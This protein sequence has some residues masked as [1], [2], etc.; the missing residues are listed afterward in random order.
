M[1]IKTL[2]RKSNSRNLKAQA[3]DSHVAADPP[4]Q[5]TYP[6]A[7]NGPNVLDDLQRSHVRR[8][9]V[10]SAAPSPFVPRSR[11]E[12]PQTA[13]YSGFP[14]GGRRNSLPTSDNASERTRSG[15][16]MSSTF[17]SNRRSS[18]AN[19]KAKRASWFPKN[20]TPL[21]APAQIQT[22]SP[23]AEIETHQ[24][25]QRA[26]S[27]A[28]KHLPGK[29]PTHTMHASPRSASYYPPPTKSTSSHTRSD[30]QLSRISHVDVLDAQS[31]LHRA[32]E[33]HRSKGTVS[34]LR[35]FG[36]HVADRN[37]VRAGAGNSTIDFDSPEFSYVKKLYSPRRTTAV[38]RDSE[39]YQTR[40]D[41][42]LGHILGDSILGDD[43]QPPGESTSHR[44]GSGP[45]PKPV[46]TYP[47]RTDSAS[48]HVALRNAKVEM[49]KLPPKRATSSDSNQRRSR[50]TSL[51]S[52][53]SLDDDC[54]IRYHKP[55]SPGKRSKV[56]ITDTHDVLN[57]P[58]PDRGRSRIALPAV[59]RIPS[60]IKLNASLTTPHPQTRTISTSRDSTITSSRPRKHSASS[61]TVPTQ[62][63]MG[64]PQESHTQHAVSSTKAPNIRSKEV[65]HSLQGV[66]GQKDS[67][68]TSVVNKILSGR[69]PRSQSR[70]SV[71]S[72]ASSYHAPYL[73]P[74]HVSPHDIVELPSFP[75]NWSN[76]PPVPN[77]PQSVPQSSFRSASS[78]K[79]V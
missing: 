60:N 33:L 16:S 21:P 61:I 32:K 40:V 48:S 50:P 3:Y 76:P 74:L 53:T 47:P 31:S 49:Q 38:V 27:D 73:S 66:V 17:L 22:A 69:Y 77:L 4:I 37:M 55:L 44:S 14:W 2:F 35:D 75:P 46:K 11:D 24:P 63:K 67:V 28:V 62:N 72:R 36:E 68:D 65:Q 9:S 15:F 56:I 30:S 1:G 6:V 59:P 41:S 78:A 64:L 71:A 10:S 18:I 42:A 34:G 19:P 70:S 5:G 58:V 25:T 26:Q 43:I 45:R 12:R 29:Q 79:H 20:E 13:P 39:A 54:K 23:R 57:A 7:G 51:S 8:T 52:T